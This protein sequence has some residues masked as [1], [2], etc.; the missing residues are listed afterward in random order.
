MDE[1]R[2]VLVRKVGYSA[3]EAKAA[4]TLIHSRAMM[5]KPVRLP[6]SVC[7]DPDDDGVLATALAGGAKGIVTGDKDLTMLKS[8][9]AG[10]KSLAG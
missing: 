4:S 7:R 1:F 10:L 5:V 3:A 6:R 2:D 8:Y 9:S